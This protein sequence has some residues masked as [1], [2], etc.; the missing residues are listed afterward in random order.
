MEE[1]QKALKNCA[2]VIVLIGQHWFSGEN[3]K[4]LDQIGD[5]V[6]QEI[7]QALKS[8]AKVY[9]VLVHGARMPAERDLPRD[10]QP[11]ARRHAVEIRDVSFAADVQQLF[12]VLEKLEGLGAAAGKVGRAASASKPTKSTKANASSRGEDVIHSPVGGTRKRAARDGARTP[13]T[14]RS[15]GSRGAA[16]LEGGSRATVAAGATRAKTTRKA[17]EAKPK[18]APKEPRSSPAA[19]ARSSPT[20]KRKSMGAGNNSAPKPSVKTS[21][22]KQPRTSRAKQGPSVSAKQPKRGT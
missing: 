7:A 5:H 8:K 9:P 3:R 2:A 15:S 20:V 10:I 19:E 21:G 13:N 6:R 17:T 1:V 18:V 12:K 14:G 11:L 4:R 22:A 16:A